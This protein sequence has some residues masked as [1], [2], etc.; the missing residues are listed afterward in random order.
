MADD[1]LTYGEAEEIYAQMLAG[2]D[3]R[4]PEIAELYDDLYRRAVR[5]AGIRASW[6]TLTR[7]QKLAADS[8]RTSAH[9]AFIT[10]VNIIARLQGQSGADFQEK[11][12]PQENSRPGWREQLG[13]GRK[14]IGDFACYLAL[15]MGLEAR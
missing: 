14:R 15:F 1:V 2:A 6:N 10:S 7:E 9:D 3:R 13:S 11:E 12:D 5:Y 8:S 4:D